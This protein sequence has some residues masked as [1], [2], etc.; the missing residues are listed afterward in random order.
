MS[1]YTSEKINAKYA[2]GT[3]NGDRK[4]YVSCSQKTN[5]SEKNTS[6]I[7]WTL[8]VTGGGTSYYDTGPTTLTIGGV[9]RYYHDRAYSKV[10]GSWNKE[11]PNCQGDT[12]GSFTHN[13]ATDG[14]GGK[15]T[16]TL[17]TAMYTGT[18]STVS[19][20]W[21]LDNIARYFSTT[22]TLTIGDKTET[23]IPLTWKTSETCSLVELY[24]KKE[25]DS[26]YTKLSSAIYNNSTGATTGSYT[27]T[28]L[29]ANTTYNIY[30]KAKRKDSGLQ[31]DSAMSTV[32]TWNYPHVISASQSE[33]QI[34]SSQTLKIY[35]PLGKTLYIYMSNTDKSTSSS[36]YIY[37]SAAYTTKSESEDFPFT[38]DAETLYKKIPSAQSTKTYY[39]C[40]DG[41]SSTIASVQGSYKIK[42]TEVPTFTTSSV[43]FWDSNTNITGIT[44]QGEGGWLV[45]NLSTLR[46]KVKTAAKPQNSAS[47]SKYEFT[48]NN[49]T[50]TVTSVTSTADS[51]PT[52]NGSGTKEVTV[53][54][55]DS[56][57]LS[58]TIKPT[59]VFKPYSAPVISLVAKRKNNYGTEV[60]LTA[61]YS[62]ASVESKN[63][64]TASWTSNLPS[65]ASATKG[66]FVSSGTT[67][68]GNLTATVTA[69][70]NEN[71][72]TF[73]ATVTDR[74]GGTS[75]S[76][77]TITRGVPIMFVDSDVLGVG[78]N[79][80]PTVAGL[81]VNGPI[82]TNGN[83]TASGTLTAGTVKGNIQ[84]A[85]G[86][87]YAYGIKANRQNFTVE[88]D[89]NTYYPVLIKQTYGNTSFAYGTYHIYRGYSEQA[90][91]SW[92][93]STHKG[94]L[95]FSFYW[96]GDI[97]WGGNDHNLKVLELNE[98]YCKMVGGITLS[99]SGLLVWLRGGTAIYHM[100][101]DIGT[102]ATAT[103]CLDGYTDSAGTKYTSRTYSE[104]QT[105]AIHKMTLTHPY[106]VGSIYMSTDTTSP[107][108]YF[109]GKWERLKDRFLLGAG[110]TYTT[111]LG[112]GGSASSVASHTHEISA[113]DVTSSKVENHSHYIPNGSSP[114]NSGDSP[115]FESWPWC[116]GSTRNHWTDG[117][118]AHTHTVSIP[119]HNTVSTGTE[120]GNMPPYLIVYMWK[121]I[122]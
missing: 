14:T 31:T 85:S 98:S 30:I 41:S 91:S 108:S 24:Y 122:K 44:S 116:G 35:N 29:I 69:V 9:Q 104:D 63:R 15:L 95:T 39:Y 64:V 60:N 89:A 106:P 88:G 13:H 4:M 115:R 120:N 82:K 71:S 112:T 38:P 2:D 7:S 65:T 50:K 118:G 67:L 62:V 107:A 36:V 28:G 52:F 49:V 26:S 54:V 43:A 84:N 58:T 103:V 76:S 37:K 17:S 57:G 83:V 70:P 21:T 90:P 16:V 86:I 12:S 99:T 101:T 74:F 97:G 79:T 113:F 27:L 25:S 110:D 100:E 55:T 8:Y 47:I 11:F 61:T 102:A 111:L 94:G 1:T 105:Y 20:E 87:P 48:F 3:N 42:G 22:P 5:G 46:A 23:T 40:Y 109:G 117:A 19:G 45:Q 6:T 66:T 75:S 56:R 33:L 32:T 18:I 72:Y 10:N 96:S 53:K 68:S 77:A 81:D 121:R 92:N 114:S 34:G 51:W 59:V 78:I 119:K 80:F 73:T 93:T